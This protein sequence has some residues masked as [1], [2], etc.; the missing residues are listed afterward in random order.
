MKNCSFHLASVSFGLVALCAL[1]ASA[2]PA[3]S[4][5][6]DGTIAIKAGKIHT[7]GDAGIVENAV[8]IVRDG[9]VVSV[10]AGGIVAP[11]MQLVDYGSDATI[12]PGLVSASSG[13]AR[14]MPDPRSAAPGLS[15]LDNFD[16]FAN[17]ISALAS[18]VTSTYIDP[19]AGRLVTGT[20]AVVKLGGEG[21]EHRTVN[22][23]SAIDGSVAA[24]AYNTPGFWEPPVPAT[25]D[26]GMGQEEPQLPHS[27]QGAIFA[28]E[29]LLAGAM[30]AETE[31]F[32]PHA[33]SELPAPTR[34]SHGG[35]QSPV[36]PLGASLRIA[37]KRSA[38]SRA[39][40]VAT[41]WS[42][43]SMVAAQRVPPL[44]CSR[45]QVLVS[46]S[47]RPIALA[48]RPTGGSPRTA[49]G[50]VSR[51]PLSCLG[52]AFQSRLLLVAT[53]RLTASG[54]LAF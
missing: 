11:G 15:A 22:G 38:R 30:G 13:L 25:V 34:L 51:Y 31:G 42:L 33:T 5:V 24:D 36:E 54:H 17:R 41:S 28:L 9:R 37:R 53:I 26:V 16:F 4:T 44:A 43:S 29:R 18:G 14:G 27:L 3:N 49:N 1:S 23:A 10:T 48:P 20:G 2:T 45:V 21:R 46:S 47:S 32:G 52:L 6:G 39:S 7:L 50:R 19:A 35:R 8:M 12:I 40:P